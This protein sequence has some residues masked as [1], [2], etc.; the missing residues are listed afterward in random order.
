MRCVFSLAFF[1]KL[2]IIQEFWF[3]QKYGGEF[4]LI[5]GGNMTDSI[6]ALIKDLIA[7]QYE[8]EW[9]EFKVNWYEP[10]ILGEYISALSNAAALSGREHAYLIWGIEDKTHEVVGTNFDYRRNVNNEPLPHFLARQIKPDIALRFKEIIFQRKRVVVLTIPAAQKAPTAFDKA[11]YMRIGSSKIN[12]MNF[13]EH[14]AQLFSVLRNGVPTLENTESEYQ[15]LTFGKL[16]V[17]YEAKGVPLNRRKFKENLGFFTSAGK[18]NM[19]AQLM[20]DNSHIP[21]RFSLF[22]GKDK[23]STMYSVRE[24]GNTCLLYSLDDVIQ[25]G[26]ILNIPIADEHNRIVERKE[27]MMFDKDAFREAAINAFVHNRWIDGNAPMFTGY[28]NRIEILSH[29]NLPPKQTLEGFYAGRSIPVNSGLSDI[30]LQLHISERSGRGI[31]KIVGTYGRENI[32]IEEKSITVTIPYEEENVPVE[33]ENAPVEAEN[34]PVNR[35]ERILAYCIE[36]KSISE[37]AEMLGYKDKR[38]VRKLLNPMLEIGRISRTIPDKPNSK[39]QKY[40]TIK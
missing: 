24:F 20:S 18:Y 16:M 22:T 7:H 26:N 14:E 40:I 15:E 4:S 8:E 2:S 27:I 21:L 9:F 38:S 37:I 39:S 1:S 33:A 13:P 19:L 29:G 35:Q 5:Y 11:R 23:T 30:I 10:K 28:A 25:Y 6:I 36:P 31:P 12:L 3:W 17:Y 32:N 34:A